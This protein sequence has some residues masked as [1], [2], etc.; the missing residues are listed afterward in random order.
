MSHVRISLVA[1]LKIGLAEG[2]DNE[3]TVTGS[4]SFLTGTMGADGKAVSVGVMMRLEG[5]PGQNK[6]RVTAR[7]KHP[8]VAQVGGKCVLNS[9]HL[10]YNVYFIH[11]CTIMFIKLT[12][13]LYIC[14]KSTLM[15]RMCIKP[16]RILHICIK[17]TLILHMCIKPPLLMVCMCIKPTP[18]LVWVQPPR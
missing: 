17:S 13:I 5:D 18:T 1:A 12:L 14:F 9:L 7:A 11:S 4:A 10:Y 16:T 2:L 15:L 3:K 8:A 6:F